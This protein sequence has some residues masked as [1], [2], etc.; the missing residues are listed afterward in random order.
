MK[1]RGNTRKRGNKR[2]TRNTRNTRNRRIIKGGYVTFNDGKLIIN[3]HNRRRITNNKVKGMF[4]VRNSN[5]TQFKTKL[6]EGFKNNE[7]FKTLVRLFIE[8]KMYDD[9][10]IVNR[11]QTLLDN[12]LLTLDKNE[13]KNL[14]DAYY[15]FIFNF[16]KE[17]PEP[18][19]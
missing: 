9:Q 3:N 6:P 19:G 13:N 18:D 5:K 17:Q 14:L 4:K 15:T 11:T 2:N 16:K 8:T 7:T 10:K 12:K 1:K